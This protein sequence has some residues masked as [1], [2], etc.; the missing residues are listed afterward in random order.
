MQACKSFGIKH[1]NG[2]WFPKFTVIVAQKNHHTRFFMLKESNRNEGRNEPNHN[3]RR[4]VLPDV[5]NV[6]P[7]NLHLHIILRLPL[8]T[9]L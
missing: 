6:H 1:F 5:I 2:E 7:G 8:Y 3:E 4:N 9:V